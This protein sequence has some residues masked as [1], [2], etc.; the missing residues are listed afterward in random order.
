MVDRKR[1]PIVVWI[2]PLFVG[3]AGFYRVTQ[4]PSFE[5][6]RVVDIVQILGCGMC[7]DSVMVV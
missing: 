4:S 1:P 2:I 5:L 3:L 7:F 6:Y